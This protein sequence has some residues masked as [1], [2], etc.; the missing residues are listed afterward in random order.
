MFGIDDA[1]IAIAR[2]TSTPDPPL[3]EHP[4]LLGSKL[5]VTAELGQAARLRKHTIRGRHRHMI[6]VQREHLRRDPQLISRLIATPEFRRCSG[7]PS[8]PGTGGDSGAARGRTARSR[9]PSRRAATF[10]S[11]R[12]NTS[13]A[14]LLTRIRASRPSTTRYQQHSVYDPREGDSSSSKA[15]EGARPITQRQRCDG[16]LTPFDA[17]MGHVLSAS[18][19][20]LKALMRFNQDSASQEYGAAFGRDGRRHL[21]PA[22]Q[23]QPALLPRGTGRTRRR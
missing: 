6:G 10:R 5:D 8:S 16:S 3:P 22:E 9:S 12:R 2:G 18:T 14:R 19:P 13:A 4:G 21:Q 23:V 17:S 7:S 1:A 15:A 20:G 11:R